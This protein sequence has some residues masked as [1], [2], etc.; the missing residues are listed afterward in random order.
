MMSSCTQTLLALACAAALVAAVPSKP[1]AKSEASAVNTTEAASAANSTEDGVQYP[2]R[3]LPADV[4]RDFPG[5][6][7]GSTALRL[8]KVHQS[9]SLT[10]FCGVA[11][12][13][14]TEDGF[15]LIER[16][17]DC[18][19]QPKRNPKCHNTNAGSEASFPGCCPVYEC[20]EGA[21]LEYPS[22]EELASLAME[23][24]QEAVRAQYEEDDEEAGS[25]RSSRKNSAETDDKTEAPDTTTSSETS[26]AS[27]STASSTTASSA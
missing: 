19:P 10:P 25:S 18:G 20:E 2:F 16:V 17:Q 12:C 1:A 4:L 15:H 7:F 11:T 13:L 14:V 22:E 9:W 8:F 26:T 6:C 27:S 24:A 21:S 23:A 3:D 5:F